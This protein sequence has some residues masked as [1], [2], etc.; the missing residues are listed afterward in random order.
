MGKGGSCFNRMGKRVKDF[1]KSTV[2]P[3]GCSFR[4]KPLLWVT[5]AAVDEDTEW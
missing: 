2:L 3:R 5:A 4:R 1:L